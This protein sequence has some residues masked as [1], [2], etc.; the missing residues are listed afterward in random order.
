[1]AYTVT[2]ELWQLL[3]NHIEGKNPDDFVFEING[4]PIPTDRLYKVW[5][6]ACRQA[7][8]KHISLQQASR[9]STASEINTK[10]KKKACQEIQERLGHENITTGPKHYIVER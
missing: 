1:M 9:H 6:A 4:S 8:V 10:H 7:K 2:P 5:A 3:R